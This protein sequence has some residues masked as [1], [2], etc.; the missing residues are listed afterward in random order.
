ME[1]TAENGIACDIIDKDHNKSDD[2]PNNNGNVN[3]NNSGN[4][5][6]SDNDND[7]DSDSDDTDYNNVNDNDNNSNIN[8]K[9]VV[10]PKSDVGANAYFV[11]SSSTPTKPLAWR[12]SSRRRIFNNR[13]INDDTCFRRHSSDC[14]VIEKL[15]ANIG[16]IACVET[17][18]KLDFTPTGYFIIQ[19][20]TWYSAFTRTLKG[21]DRWQMYN[22]IREIV[23]LA[24]RIAGESSDDDE[25]IRDALVECASG[26]KSLIETYTEDV[27]LCSNLRILLQR[28]QTRYGLR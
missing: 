27:T 28:I 18:D 24:E 19:K 3:V 7:S 2:D 5:S 4:D 20:P 14:D 8:N 22:K 11:K 12:S 16:I 9:G 10:T 26:L 25:R 15:L 13:T 1:T 6:D 21:T 17:G 23:G